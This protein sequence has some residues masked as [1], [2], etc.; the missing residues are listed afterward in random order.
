MAK[1]S[2]WP[3]NGLRSRG[4]LK[5]LKDSKLILHESKLF[6]WSARVSLAPFKTFRGPLF[7]KSVTGQELFLTVSY[8]RLALEQLSIS[9]W[10]LKSLSKF[11]DL[12]AKRKSKTSQDCL[13]K[14]SSQVLDLDFKFTYIHQR[15]VIKS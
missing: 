5:D 9:T 2:S 3:V 10:F 13:I 1:K 8:C 6:P 7:P 14:K 15:P 12:K 4:P 11:W